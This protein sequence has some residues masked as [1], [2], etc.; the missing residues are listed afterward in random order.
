M[1]PKLFHKNPRMQHRGV[2]TFE[3]MLLFALLTIGIIGGIATMRDTITTKY[4]NVGGALGAL[5]M[6]YDVPETQTTYPTL[7]HT[8]AS[9]PAQKNEARPVYVTI[10]GNLGAKN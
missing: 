6:S 2:L 9:A 1:S 8:N 3:W 4:A 7:K 10:G 5:D